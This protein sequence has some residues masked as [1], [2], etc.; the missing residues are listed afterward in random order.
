[1]GDLV[2]GVGVQAG[3][4]ETATL[5]FLRVGHTH[6][7]IDQFFN[8]I[9]SL[10]LRCHHYECP[11]ELLA[12]LAKEL[13]PKFQARQEE[14]HTDVVTG[15]RDWQHRLCDLN[16]SISK[17]FGNRQGHKAP[18]S[19]IFKLG[20]GLRPAGQRRLQGRTVE[21]A[22]V[23]AF[24]RDHMSSPDLRQAPVV[25]LP[26]RRSVNN[27][28]PPTACARCP[29]GSPSINNYTKLALKSQELG[30][31][32]AANAL[33]SLMFDHSYNLPHCHGWKIHS[34][35]SGGLV[36]RVGGHQVASNLYFPHLPGSF[37]L[38]AM[39]KRAARP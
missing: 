24:V 15:I 32:K 27:P 3:L 33:Q 4:F 35:A 25:V 7:D 21:R 19:F 31:E 2:F 8:L 37:D 20:K 17:Y 26:E 1:M 36:S 13:S 34:C 5:N 14:V 12:F 28:L 23:I 22:D 39:D 16:R 9:V 6:E 38:V 10:I 30:L 29:L 18:H 11:E